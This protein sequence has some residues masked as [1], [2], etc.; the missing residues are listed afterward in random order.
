MSCVCFFSKIGLVLPGCACRES[1]HQNRWF[2]FQGCDYSTTTTFT[3][4]LCLYITRLQLKYTIIQPLPPKER[5]KR[6][7][8][9][10]PFCPCFVCVQ[11]LSPFS[12]L[13]CDSSFAL[14]AKL[15]EWTILE[16]TR[17]RS[18]IFTRNFWD[19]F[20]SAVV[21]CEFARLRCRSVTVGFAYLF[22]FSLYSRF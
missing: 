4:H 6:D 9:L 10:P 14:R 18:V 2:F 22:L 13:F 3:R 19:N 5:K 12:S 21:C 17:A 8:P 20:F 16:C 11:S 1:L 7:N 15:L